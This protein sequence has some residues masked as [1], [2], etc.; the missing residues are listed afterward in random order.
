MMR[1]EPDEDA[2]P[3]AELAKMIYV[4]SLIRDAVECEDPAYTDLEWCRSQL[5]LVRRY[6]RKV[7]G[8][9]ECSE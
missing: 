2:D 9:Q 1:D 8:D 6:V 4:L 7:F 3:R 5:S